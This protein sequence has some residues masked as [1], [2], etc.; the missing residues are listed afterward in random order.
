MARRSRSRGESGALTRRLPEGSPPKTL[1]LSEAK[2]KLSALVDEVH[3]TDEEIVITRN[4]V[5]EDLGDH[6]GVED[7]SRSNP[8]WSR[9]S[10]PS[11]APSRASRKTRWPR[12]PGAAGVDREPRGR[13]R[14]LVVPLV[15]RLL[16]RGSRRAIL[17]A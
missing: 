4:G 11:A 6:P 16:L 10:A 7:E 1:S 14:P 5:A 13:A 8:A 3:G 12:R 2:M 15:P 17:H 9:R